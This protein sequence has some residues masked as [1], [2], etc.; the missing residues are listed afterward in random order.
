M[1]RRP[2]LRKTELTGVT[3]VDQSLARF[4]YEIR[5]FVATRD[6]SAAQA[7][8]TPQ[9]H[10]ALLA[11]KGFGK[12]S[13]LTVG[14]LAGRLFLRHHTVVE[15]ADRLASLGL[16]ARS[17]DPG[18]GRRV[19]LSLTSEGQRRLRQLSPL[20]IEDLKAIRGA[21]NSLIETMRRQQ[22]D[23]P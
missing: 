2:K 1:E 18:D 11:I 22:N 5:R 7:G 20:R 4:R 6:K 23:P 15:L 17:P 19:V 9:H 14:D 10:Q 16:I 3:A 13:C 8:L 12:D 21:L